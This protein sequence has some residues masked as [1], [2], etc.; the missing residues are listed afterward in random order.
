MTVYVAEIN[1]Q[2][3][4]A[5]DAANDSAAEKLELNLRDDWMVLESNGAS[6]WDG[7]AEIFVRKA[8][9]E[10]D[11]HWEA[12]RARAILAGEIEQN[13]EDNDFVV[14]LLYLVPVTDPTDEEFE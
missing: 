3:I 2:A 9:S 12:S 5:F 6:L 4:A 1:G 7:Q 13:A 10:E 8:F 14:H 11:A